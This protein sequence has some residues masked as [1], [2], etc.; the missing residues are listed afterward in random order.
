MNKLVGETASTPRRKSCG[1][2][3]IWSSSNFKYYTKAPSMSVY[4]C[5]NDFIWMRLLHRIY[6]RSA[7]YCCCRPICW[8]NRQPDSQ[9]YSL[10]TTF[11]FARN[12]CWHLPRI[13]FSAHSPLVRTANYTR[14][15]S[16]LSCPSCHAGV[17]N[18]AVAI[19]T[20][21]LRYR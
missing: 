12:C 19:N 15:S 5:T 16:F 14:T 20:Q 6:K 18:M 4:N 17:S 2:W 1:K 11:P 9:T 21:V 8:L 3:K 13:Y 10:I 7:K